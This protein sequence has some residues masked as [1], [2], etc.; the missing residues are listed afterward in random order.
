VWAKCEGWESHFMLSGVWE[1]VR[2]WATTLPSE[3]PLW[4]LES[5]WSLESSKSNCKGQNPLDRV[6]CII[7][8]F[9]ELKCLNWARMTKCVDHHFSLECLKNIIDS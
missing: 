6:P 8:K 3:L 7:G 4:E 5:R 1:S 9:L 2:E